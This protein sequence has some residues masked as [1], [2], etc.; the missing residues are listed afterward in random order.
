MARDSLRGVGG[1]KVVAWYGPQVF[2]RVD[3]GVYHGLQIAGKHL[4]DQVRGTLGGPANS[5]EGGPPGKVSGELQKSIGYK[6]GRAPEGGWKMKVGVVKGGW[7]VYAK[8]VRLSAGF[9]GRD[10]LGRFYSQGP[11]PFLVPVMKT[12]AVR[13][14]EAFVRGARGI[15]GG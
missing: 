13:T 7:E 14:N 2:S 1:A 11:R 9:V 6:I 10:R 12:E 15:I 3:R 8:A 4:A 5:P